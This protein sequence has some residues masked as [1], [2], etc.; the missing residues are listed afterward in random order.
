MFSKNNKKQQS[1]STQPQ[2]SQKSTHPSLISG[3]LKIVGDLQSDGEIQVDGSVDGDVRSKT[4]LIGE[5]GNVKGQIIADS[6]VIH[7]TVI[8]QI[9]S[10]S[11]RLAQSAHMVGDILH[12]NLAIET[13]AFLEGLCQRIE[14]EK[15]TQSPQ[16]LGSTKSKPAETISAAPENKTSLTQVNST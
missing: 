7:G 8:G 6:V 1:R 9:K 15:S 4:L 3:N 14:E 5:N 2:T 16:S 12:E 10:R 13:G 11:V